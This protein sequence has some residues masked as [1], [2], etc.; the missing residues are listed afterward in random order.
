MSYESSLAVK[1]ITL[2]Y[3]FDGNITESQ[4]GHSTTGTYAQG[5]SL[6]PALGTAK[7]LLCSS[8]NINPAGTTLVNLTSNGSYAYSFW[9]KANSVSGVQGIYEEGGGS[10]WVGIFLDGSA[11]KFHIGESS[12]VKG[13]VVPM[14]SVVTGTVYHVVCNYNGSGNVAKVFVNGNEYTATTSF[15]TTLSSHSGDVTIGNSG[16]AR[17]FNA[18]T[19]N[20]N[21][22][23]NGHVQDFV[24]YQACGT[25]T[26]SEALAIYTDGLVSASL[27]DDEKLVTFNDLQDLVDNEGY[28]A[29]S[30]IPV[31][32]EICKKGDV[33]TY[34]DIVTSGVFG[35]LGA[36]QKVP[37]GAIIDDAVGQEY[38]WTHTLTNVEPSS[39]ASTAGGTEVIV[40][41]ENTL[42]MIDEIIQTKAGGTF[43][44]Q[45]KWTAIERY[46]S[47]GTSQNIR[48]DSTGKVT[49]R[50]WCQDY[51][52]AATISTV[53]IGCSSITISVVTN[54][55][56]L[57]PS[58]RVFESV[59][60]DI[61]G[62]V[63]GGE[64]TFTYNGGAQGTSDSFTVRTYMD[65]NGTGSYKTSN[66]LNV[67]YDTCLYPITMS[68]IPTQTTS[69]GACSASDSIGY[70]Y[71]GLNE[72][73]ISNGDRIYTNAGGTTPFN[74]YGKYFKDYDNNR[75]MLVDS[76]GYV[77][78][79]ISC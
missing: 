20:Q 32:D 42:P 10:H 28:T 16:D 75:A 65:S 13:L 49:W 59:A 43:D 67:T 60:G 58:Y 66:T 73:G 14:F 5:D 79:I 21:K 45:N 72:S 69:A 9:F 18:S 63:N 52:V 35:A 56:Y 22:Y 68:Y 30:T 33:S 3:K 2:R 19:G 29:L 78:S 48:V 53:N 62:A 27:F 4:I 77:T 34:L 76:S 51:T 61:S 57:T 31:S 54:G 25:W 74:G 17:D 47:S 41:G 6:I 46:P 15:G 11:L 36:N 70:Y 1:T 8:A 37:R 24:F 64:T 23:F 50:E 40:I 55:E 7:S 39:C 12:A 44:G 71:D 38:A 26:A